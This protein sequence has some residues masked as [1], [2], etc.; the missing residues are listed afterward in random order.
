M[1]THVCKKAPSRKFC[2]FKIFDDFPED[3]VEAFCLLSEESD[4][5]CCSS[6]CNFLSKRSEC[7]VTNVAD[8]EI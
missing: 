6:V 8:G 5:F 7:G 3:K 2:L 4:S 1:G